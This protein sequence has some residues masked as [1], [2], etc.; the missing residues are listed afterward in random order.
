MYGWNH[1]HSNRS[2]LETV[3]QR[4]G[5]TLSVPGDLARLERRMRLGSRI[6][7]PRDIWYQLSGL[8]VIAINRTVSCKLIISETSILVPPESG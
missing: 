5:L 3:P 1:R 8:P 4:D 2:I 6:A 7:P